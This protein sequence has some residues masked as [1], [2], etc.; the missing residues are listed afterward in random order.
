MP[1]EIP[2]MKMVKIDEEREDNSKKGKEGIKE[3]EWQMWHLNGTRC[4][5]G[6]VPVRRSTVNDVLRSKSLYDFGKK[7]SRSLPLARRVDAP[8]V[9]NGNGHEVRIS[10]H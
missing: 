8:D 7:R 9:V 6:T 1:S 3:I 5:K 2:R 4:P 10:L